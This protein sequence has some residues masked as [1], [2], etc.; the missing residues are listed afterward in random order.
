[1]RR[2]FEDNFLNELFILFIL[3]TVK[4]SENCVNLSNERLYYLLLHKKL[5]QHLA[6]SNKNYY[7]T[8]FLWIRIWDLS[9]VAVI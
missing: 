9:W 8:Q 4:I 1:M 2:N 7:L 5:P 6:A 3:L